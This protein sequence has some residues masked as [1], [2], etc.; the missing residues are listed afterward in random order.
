MIK[1]MKFYDTDPRVRRYVMPTRVIAAIGG[2]ERTDYLLTYRNRQIG[3][4]IKS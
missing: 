3:C 1:N 2:V 4:R